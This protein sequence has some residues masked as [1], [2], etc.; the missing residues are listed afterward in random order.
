MMEWQ[1]FTK[2][3]LPPVNTGVLIWY[4]KG[5]GAYANPLFFSEHCKEIHIGA[6]EYQQKNSLSE[7]EDSLR[8]TH[9]MLFP[10]G[11]KE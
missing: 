7:Y 4:K 11:P 1:K 8:I 3:N 10:E 2:D 5:S 6:L 9:W